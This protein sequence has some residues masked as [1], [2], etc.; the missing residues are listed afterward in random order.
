MPCSSGQSGDKGKKTRP[1][2]TSG[3]C[4][5]RCHAIQKSCARL[6][7]YT[8]PLLT[9]LCPRSQAFCCYF[10]HVT[11]L[12]ACESPDDGSA[13]ESNDCRGE[14]TANERSNKCKREEKWMQ[15]GISLV[16]TL[17][18]I[19]VAEKDW[20]RQY[21]EVKT[22]KKTKTVTW[23]KKPLIFASNGNELPLY[24]PCE[25]KK[26]LGYILTGMQTPLGLFPFRELHTTVFPTLDKWRKHK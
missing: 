9:P 20:D 13:C 23:R 1:T 11:G 8:Y 25:R 14:M 17:S 2:Q 26:K 6:L 7:L 22:E 5:I 10:T 12:L 21:D 19:T 18:R 24:F 4:Q 15:K 3:R 16:V